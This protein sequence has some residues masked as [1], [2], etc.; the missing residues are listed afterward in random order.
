MINRCKCLS[1]SCGLDSLEDTVGEACA[2]CAEAISTCIGL[3]ARGDAYTH[4]LETVYFTVIFVLRSIH[5]LVDYAKTTANKQIYMIL[6][7]LSSWIDAIVYR[8]LNASYD[9]RR[10]DID[11]LKVK[12]LFRSLVH[13]Y[14]S[15]IDSL[16]FQ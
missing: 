16:L 10:Y 15:A 14:V 12:M 13:V 9:D 4:I 3:F 2:I 7:T 11:K 5:E 1:R 8:C 6:R